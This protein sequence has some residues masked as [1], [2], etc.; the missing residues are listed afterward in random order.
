MLSRSIARSP[1]LLLSA[2]AAVFLSSTVALAHASDA[3]APS[4]AAPA[5]HPSRAAT[6]AAGAKHKAA[7]ASAKKR[8]APAHPKT[9]AKAKGR[10]VASSEKPAAATDKHVAAAAKPVAAA[11]KHVASAAHGAAPGLAATSASKRK[12]KT[13]AVRSPA[14]D[15]AAKKASERSGRKGKREATAP[16]A[17]PCATPAVTFDRGG[18]ELESFS[19]VTCGGAPIEAARERLSILARPFGVA[20]PAPGGQ[21]V[22][23]K[24][25]VDDEVATGIRRV[26]PGLVTR[27]FLIAHAFPGKSLSIVSG[28]RPSSRGSLHQTA[29]AVDVRVEGIGDAELVA[30]CKTI[31][32]TGCGYYPNSSFVHVDVRAKDTGSVHWIDASGPGESPQYVTQWPPVDDGAAVTVKAPPGA[33]PSDDDAL[34]ERP[35]REP[36]RPDHAPSAARVAP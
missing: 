4:A 32:D 35:A 17:T 19:L 6:K 7:S 11:A 27:L 36:S 20:R 33:D 30:F 23:S 15:H 9:G 25:D 29:R 8:R 3:A 34:R 21:D 12:K 24:H 1:R 31:P 10:S 2:L 22:R 13:V 5:A 18:V 28:Y 16:K 14:S 26:D